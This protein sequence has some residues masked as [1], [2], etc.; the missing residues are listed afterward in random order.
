MS[1]ASD[2]PWNPVRTVIIKCV[3]PLPLRRARH[4]SETG[5]KTRRKLIREASKRPTAI[6]KQLRGFLPSSGPELHVTNVYFIYLGY[7][8]SVARWKAFLTMR[9]IQLLLYSA[10][11]TFVVSTACGG[12]TCFK[13]LDHIYRIG[14]LVIGYFYRILRT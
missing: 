6:L 10:K 2:V 12:E 9:N 5:E 8:G 7:E 13:L 4:R 14:Y 1:K 3:T 11:N